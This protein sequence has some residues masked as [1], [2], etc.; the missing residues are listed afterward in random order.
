MKARP[1]EYCAFGWNDQN[2]YSHTTNMHLAKATKIVWY[3]VSVAH[4]VAIPVC[5]EHYAVVRLVSDHSYRAEL[6]V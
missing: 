2:P 3:R 4:V 1:F 5:E 6:W